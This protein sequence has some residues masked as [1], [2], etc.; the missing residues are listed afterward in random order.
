MSATSILQI[1]LLPLPPGKAPDPLDPPDTNLYQQ[2]VDATSHQWFLLII[3]ITALVVLVI[4][5]LGIRA[6]APG[7]TLFATA[8]LVGIFTFAILIRCLALHYYGVEKG[9]VDKAS[10]EQVIN[11]QGAQ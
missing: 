11:D 6:H 8:S 7:I 1:I 5:I 2:Y 3:G 4:T 9:Y 10:I